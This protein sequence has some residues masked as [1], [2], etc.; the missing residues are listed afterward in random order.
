MRR[1]LRFDSRQNTAG[2][3]PDAPSPSNSTAEALT[4]E[5]VDQ[6]LGDE[7]Q[8][9]LVLE[10]ARDT[11]R[12]KAQIF[13]HEE[14]L[15]RLL[16]QL[17]SI[18]DLDEAM[19]TIL[20]GLADAYKTENS[21]RQSVRDELAKIHVDNRSHRDVGADISF[22]LRP[23][24]PKPWFLALQA[25]ADANGLHLESLVWCLYANLSFLEHPSRRIGA[26]PQG[27][28]ESINIP[29]F[30]GGSPSTRKSF[31]LAKTND[32]MTQ[33]IHAPQESF[34]Q[35]ECIVA[36]GTVAGL[37]QSMM[38]Y[39]RAAVTCDEATNVYDTLPSWKEGASGVRYLSKTKLN[40]YT[41]S[42]PDDQVT[43]KS[44][45][46]LGCGD[47]AYLFLHKARGIR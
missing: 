3:P 43:G 23:C 37:R 1:R 34:R 21:I 10:N 45:V 46:H 20:P 33:N 16:Q 8:F 17:S 44:G 13:S 4:Q 24:L 18:A 28:T 32:F 7:L 26:M 6:H 31:L 35:R 40:N 42:E 47:D 29:V 15:K 27:Y 9:G 12:V 41:M 38:C 19:T 5:D 39:G 36:D 11:S 22:D 30:V 25:Y 14:D 2:T